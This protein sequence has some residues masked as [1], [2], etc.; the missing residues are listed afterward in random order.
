MKLAY[1]RPDGGVS[2]VMAAPKE[3]LE[4]ALGKMTQEQYEA[5][6]L[7]RSIPVDAIEVVKLPDDWIAPDRSTRNAWR[8]RDG[9]IV[10]EH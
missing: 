8:L 3:A 6:V 7:K 5:H 9:K 1:S 2:I 4:R 10:V